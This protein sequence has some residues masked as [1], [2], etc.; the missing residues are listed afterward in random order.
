MTE[1]QEKREEAEDLRSR[2]YKVNNCKCGWPKEANEFECVSC[3]LGPHKPK[4]FYEGVMSASRMASA[5]A[6]AARKKCRGA[7]CVEDS[8]DGYCIHE[9]QWNSLLKLAHDL[10]NKV[11]DRK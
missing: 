9:A 7:K 2:G 11:K 5:R 10:K 4:S 1:A 3:R 8:P 6:G